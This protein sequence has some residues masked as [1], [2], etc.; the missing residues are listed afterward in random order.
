[1]REPPNQKFLLSIFFTA[2]LF[3][4]CAFSS[5]I[6]LSP[7][8]RPYD[9]L[10][11]PYQILYKTE[12]FSFQPPFNS[13]WGLCTYMEGHTAVIKNNKITIYNYRARTWIS[14]AY[15]KLAERQRFETQR[16]LIQA[17]VAG[18]QEY[19]AGNSNAPIT[20][21]HLHRGF[22]GMLGPSTPKTEKIGRNYFKVLNWYSTSEA[23]KEKL[24]LKLYVTPAK[25]LSGIFVIAMVSPV[26][27]LASGG[28]ITKDL[29]MIVNNFRALR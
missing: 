12:N 19:L 21:I 16:D 29:E 25:D 20:K 9:L 4:A 27:P 6:Y 23:G 3:Q 26:A 2:V 7:A 18:E 5:D 1:M 10:T 22:K 11:I 24:H 17:F 15:L 28:N 8:T 13:N 14:V